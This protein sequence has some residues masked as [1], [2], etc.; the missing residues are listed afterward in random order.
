[1]A[2]QWVH[3]RFIFGLI[4]ILSSDLA[5]GLENPFLMFADEI[6]LSEK[7]NSLPLIGKM[8]SPVEIV[9]VPAAYRWRNESPRYIGPTGYQVATERVG[10]L[11]ILM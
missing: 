8:G 3:Q 6:Q 5:N 7:A 11:G 4:L 10:N 2:I 1:M 9:Q